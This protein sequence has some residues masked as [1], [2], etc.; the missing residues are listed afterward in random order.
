MPRADALLQAGRDRLRPILM[1]TATTVLGLVPLAL[2]STHV[3]DVMYYPL[4]RTVIG[5]LLVS[6]ALT[7]VLVPCLYTM[8]EDGA[9]LVGQLW[10][11]G[12]R[13]A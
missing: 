11:R 4:A 8:L 2:G 13:A 9:G 12:P 7:L 10:R 5:G 3:G 1:T 6:T